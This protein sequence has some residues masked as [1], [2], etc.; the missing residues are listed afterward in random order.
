M[1]PRVASLLGQRDEPRH[2]DLLDRTLQRRVFDAVATHRD[3]ETLGQD[4]ADLAVFRAAI[5]AFVDD[6]SNVV[7]RH[8]R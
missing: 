3:I 4:D 2:V 1:V 5:V 7:P 6:R 8:L